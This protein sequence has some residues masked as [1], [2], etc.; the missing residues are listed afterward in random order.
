[1]F[2][3]PNLFEDHPT[4]S[5]AA[6]SSMLSIVA[7]FI[8]RFRRISA[9]LERTRMKTTADTMA[10]E[11]AERASFRAN[12]MAEISSVRTLMKECEIEREEQRKRLNTAEGQILILKASN[13]IME[14]WV[15]FFRDHN[16][17]QAA[18]VPNPPPE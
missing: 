10:A 6:V 14:K 5:W 3:L 2:K 13:E 1:M 15:A 9:S 12:L 17:A 8:I 18:M 4:I 16:S 11:V 7:A